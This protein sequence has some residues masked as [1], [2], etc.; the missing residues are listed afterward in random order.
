MSN[1]E[2]SQRAPPASEI[3]R[4]LEAAVRRL[5]RQSA[6]LRVELRAAEG[7]NRELTGLL[8]PVARGEEGAE[9]LVEKLRAAEAERQ[10]LRKRLAKGRDVA[11]RMMARIRFLESQ[12]G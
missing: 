12:D 8:A 9:S 2:E 1:P 5:I 3:F 10:D 7:R 4:D 6:E 11:E